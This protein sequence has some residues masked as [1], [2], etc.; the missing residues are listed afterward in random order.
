LLTEIP[1]E[2]KFD[3]LL[4]CA[5][6]HSAELSDSQDVCSQVEEEPSTSFTATE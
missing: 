5:D 2:M 6:L 1:K 3:R 4:D